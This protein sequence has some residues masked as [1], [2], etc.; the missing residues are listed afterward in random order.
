MENNDFVQ[1]KGQKIAL[2]LHE[3][4][5]VAVMLAGVNKNDTCIIRGC[6][7]DYDLQAAEDVA[8]GHKI[9]LSV[10]REGEPIYKYGEKIGIARDN[11]PQGGWIHT[12][13][14]YCE[15]GM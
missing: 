11:I 7:E 1:M 15:R 14:L 10:I 13:N 12:H 8:F 3:L 4:D 2:V 5:N 9:A 6:G